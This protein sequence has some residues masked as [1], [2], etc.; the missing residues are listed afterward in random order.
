MR[1]RSWRQAVIY[2]LMPLLVSISIF[3]H[4]TYR[5]YTLTLD[6][7]ASA[8]VG[9]VYWDSGAGFDE[10]QSRT[11]P[12][13]SPGSYQQYVLHI[14]AH[15]LAGLRLDPLTGRGAF[16]LKRLTLTRG[17]TTHVWSGAELCRSL[18]PNRD[19]GS[20]TCDSGELRA[21]T[22]SIDPNLTL[23][24]VSAALAPEQSIA[25]LRLA[26]FYGLTAFGLVLLLGA[27]FSLEPLGAAVLSLLGCLYLFHFSQLSRLVVDVPFM[28]EWM[29]FNPSAI[30][31]GNLVEWIFRFYNDHCISLTRV[32]ALLNL[33][34]FGLNFAYQQ[35]FN[36]FLFGLLLL[37]V[38]ALKN[39]VVGKNTFSLFP[40]FMVFMLSPITFENHTWGF[41]SQFHIVLLLTVTGLL[42]L[43]HDTIRLPRMALL[44]LVT[45]MAINSFSAGVPMAVVM[46]LCYSGYFAKKM[47]AGDVASAE[48]LPAVAVG[49]LT[50]S[51]GLFIW[52]YGYL[53]RPKAVG[54]TLPAI[55]VC[56]DYFLNLV[57]AGFGYSTQS[58]AIGIICLCS[59][60]L[61]VLL[62]L[63]REE[64]RWRSGSW[65]ILTAVFGVLAALAAISLG[66]S[67]LGPETAKSSRYV[68][69]SF[70]LLPYAAMAWWLALRTR[71][72][73]WGVLSMFW[74]LCFIGYADN[75]DFG[76]YE[77]EYYKRLRSL[78]CIS[79]Y[80]RG[81][82]DGNCPETLTG[83]ID[84][85]YANARRLNVNF[86][87]KIM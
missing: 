86:I 53:H 10:M 58:P 85:V 66:R 20:L 43:H 8:G 73:R 23:T 27:Y 69:L 24:G 84:M 78:D 55:A 71:A 79:S 2:C 4:E 64:T 50:I 46:L 51:G 65:V 22:V 76:V 82:N 14:P 67:H 77:D 29:Y 26:A 32:L 48:L 61:P 41:Q 60:L 39:R 12:L 19:V 63:L 56:R 72:Q 62:L 37:L 35:R 13:Q 52:F 36:F 15:H 11:F 45:V 6:L 44:S 18:V 42:L 38:I 25:P 33:R 7:Q 80:A 49:W 31:S 81:D 5:G 75:W 74:L 28:D 17:A 30:L 9:Q 68:E 47:I 70:M 34:L 16:A 3:F 57:S 54:V 87:R 59:V 21:E 1:H 40:L 83:P